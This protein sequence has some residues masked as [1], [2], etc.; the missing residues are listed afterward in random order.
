MKQINLNQII[1][2]FVITFLLLNP[3]FSQTIWEGYK[4][5]SNDSLVETFKETMGYQILKKD[6][7]SL[8]INQQLLN[9][10]INPNESI[11]IDSIK[12]VIIYDNSTIKDS[13]SELIVDQI[14]QTYIKF[15]YNVVERSNIE[16]LLAEQSLS[17]SGLI[18]ESSI[19]E[20]GRFLGADGVIFTKVIKPGDFIKIQVR[21][22]ETRSS[23]VVFNSTFVESIETLSLE[24]NWS[25]FYSN[26]LP[27]IITIKCIFI[28]RGLMW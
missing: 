19:V 25:G 3:V 17:Q 15:Q 13:Y 5:V 4:D 12:T 24:K 20:T 10:L 1:L 7:F 11:N 2:K 14:E 26:W 27:Y 23:L 28:N 8:S 9:K 16:M 6:F 22:V 21:L 18:S